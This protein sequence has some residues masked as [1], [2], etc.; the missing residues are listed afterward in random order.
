[1]S[2][3]LLIPV[4]AVGAF[5]APGIYYSQWVPSQYPG[6]G[7]QKVID[8]PANIWSW[9]DIGRMNQLKT[10]SNIIIDVDS[11]NVRDQ[12]EGD[13]GVMIYQIDI[14]H[15]HR[16]VTL[17]SGNN[18]IFQDTNNGSGWTS[19][20]TIHFNPPLILPENAPFNVDLEH[21]GLSQSHD[22]YI[23]IAGRVVFY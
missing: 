2:K 15:V 16:K 12:D 9:S 19:S 22:F 1:M 6:T 23:R 4:L 3:F 11:N 21:T 10:W 14:S 13:R 8:D 18:V 17:R 5:F 7:G 20:E